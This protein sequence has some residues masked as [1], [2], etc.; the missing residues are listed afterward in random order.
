MDTELLN[1]LEEL[2]V[3]C[4]MN[5]RYAQHMLSVA[6]WWASFVDIS[7]VISTILGLALSIAAFYQPDRPL[8]PPCRIVPQWLSEMSRMDFLSLVISMLAAVAGIVLVIAP[9]S[10]NANHYGQMLQLWSGLRQEVDTALVDAM[11][12]GDADEKYL[13]HRYRDLLA[14]K[15]SLNAQEPAPDGKL[16][17]E[18][19]A[20]EERSRGVEPQR[21]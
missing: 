17:E 11:A 14:K 5:Q 19:L 2:S 10:E 12:G 21:L 16:L 1:G 7:V 4:G 8:L 3:V 9:F 6:A 13:H 18:F 15:T 20:M